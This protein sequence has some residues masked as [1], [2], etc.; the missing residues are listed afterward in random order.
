MNGEDSE[1]DKSSSL[2]DT[3][4]LKNGHIKQDSHVPKQSDATENR[5]RKSQVCDSFLVKVTYKTG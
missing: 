4:S 1:S 3:S 5:K 2:N